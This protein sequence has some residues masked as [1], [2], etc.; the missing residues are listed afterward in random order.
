MTWFETALYGGIGFFVI[1]GVVML[2]VNLK[3]RY[4]LNKPDMEN[5]S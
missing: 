3:M 2:V 1:M 4:D 5:K